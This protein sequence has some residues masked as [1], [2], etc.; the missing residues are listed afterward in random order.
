[1]RKRVSRGGEICLTANLRVWFVAS[2]LI[3]AWQLDNF[4]ELHVFLTCRPLR[5]EERSS[6]PHEKL[7]SIGV[8]FSELREGKAA[9]VDAARVR[10]QSHEVY[11]RV[12]EQLGCE[13]KAMPV[14]RWVQAPSS[15]YAEDAEFESARKQFIACTQEA[16]AILGEPGYVSM[17]LRGIK[18]AAMLQDESRGFSP[19]VSEARIVGK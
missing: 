8:Y 1:M 4:W 3:A 18:A 6:D 7:F 9:H 14:D 5:F 13:L 16:K 10:N 2:N 15:C 17:V 11:R 12:A 19:V